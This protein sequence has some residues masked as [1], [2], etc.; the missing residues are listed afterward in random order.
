MAPRSDEVAAL[1]DRAPAA[2]HR[3]ARGDRRARGTSARSGP[4]ARLESHR[5]RAGPTRETITR[6]PI[7]TR[8]R[9][10]ARQ[11]AQRRR[12]SAARSSHSSASASPS[13]RPR[14]NGTTD[15]QAASRRAHDAVVVPGGG[16]H[17]LAPHVDRRRP[18]TGPHATRR[19]L[20]PGRL[21]RGRLRAP[22]GRPHRGADARGGRHGYSHLLGLAVARRAPP[23]P[24]RRRSCTA[25]HG[26]VS[27]IANATGVQ[28]RGEL[29]ADLLELA[30]RRRRPPEK[31]R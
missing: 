3:A 14:R 9:T 29:G 31:R 20:G 1:E 18:T 10:R 21:D 8:P 28:A 23:C 5:L 24:P 30:S 11:R 15:E 6:A 4:Q 19:T 7:S 17:G 26:P 12:G 2:L 13:S 27:S 25:G 16:R 22:W